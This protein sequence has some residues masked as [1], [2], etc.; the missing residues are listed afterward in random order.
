M[1][2]SVQQIPFSKPGLRFFHRI[3]DK[4]DSSVA[5]GMNAHRPIMTMGLSHQGIESVYRMD[6]DTAGFRSVDIGTKHGGGGRTDGSIDKEL[7]ERNPDKGIPLV[8]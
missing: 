6:Q 3:Q 1:L 4:M 5:N 7:K 8:V 2:D